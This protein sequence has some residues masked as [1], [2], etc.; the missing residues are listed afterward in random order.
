MSIATKTG[1]DGTTSLLYG[2]RVSKTHAR[3][4]AYGAV[5]SFG[6]AL[7]LCRAHCAD[8]QTA[9]YLLSR[10]RDLVLLMAELATDDADQERFMARKPRSDDPARPTH[11]SAAHLQPLEDMIARCE[12]DAPAFSDWLLPGENPLQAFF[13]CARTSCREAERQAL[14]LRETGAHVR[15]ELTRYLNRFSDV[16]WL[17]GREAAGSGKPMPVQR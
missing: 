12:Q 15:P 17:L 14:L 13:D 3:V 11:I 7:G 1:D 10:Q 6:S 9:E 5:D 2:R 16:L 4:A 8:P